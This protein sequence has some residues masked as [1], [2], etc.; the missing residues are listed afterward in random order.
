[1]V[2]SKEAADAEL[3]LNKKPA[4]VEKVNSSRRLAR[5]KRAIAVTFAEKILKRETGLVKVKCII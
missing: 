2:L 3:A 5:I 1:M 4:M